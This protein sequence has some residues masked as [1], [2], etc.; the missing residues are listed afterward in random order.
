MTDINQLK[1]ERA[2]MVDSLDALMNSANGD[3][4]TDNATQF[5][6]ISK[7]VEDLNAQ[8]KR[9]ETL[10]NMKRANAAAGGATQTLSNGDKQAIKKY[11]LLNV[12]DRAAKGQSIE[13]VEAEMHQEAVR[14]ARAAGQDVQG[15]G[16]PAFMMG[17]DQ[18]RDLTV[19]T[20]TEGG[21]TVATDL[22]DM[23]PILQPKIQTQA[24]GATMLTGLRGNLDLPR[25]N[26]DASATWEGENDANAETSP[27]FDKLSLS[28]NR[29]GATVDISKQLLGQSSISVENFVKGRLNFALAK[30]VDTAAIN[31]SGS[32]NQPLGIL[33]TSG[34]G[35]VAGG[36]NGLAPTFG[37]IVDL[38]TAINTANADFGKLAYL[39]TPGIKGKLK[40]TEK[41][42][43]TG[44]FI[45]NGNELNGYS[46]ATSTLVPST[47]TK[48]SSSGVCHAII[49]GNWEELIIANWAGVDLVVDPYT[50]KTTNFLEV[51][52]NSWWDI[53]V[54]HAA[55]FAA[56]QDA[57]I[58]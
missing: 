38:E 22:G 20:T 47:L 2:Q 5:D 24:L 3:L 41:A 10:E 12:L 21:H 15:V 19:G 53:A 13:G 54:R 40:Q 58:S 31:G 6:T 7:E 32:S 34:I 35:A 28:P 49:F 57:L 48:G 39:S 18:K 4:S 1:Q 43:S 52:V 26:A 27:T 30:A 51:T 9:V 37:H 36:T 44:Q 50:K 16:L 25:N 42:S 56:M 55:S 45:W 14:E 11:S 33:G 23:I 29:L 8:I 17:L 46:A